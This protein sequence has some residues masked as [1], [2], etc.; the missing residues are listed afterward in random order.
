MCFVALRNGFRVPAPYAILSVSSEGGIV[1]PSPRG[2]AEGGIVSET[3]CS[4]S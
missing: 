1:L 2:A 4:L 3:H